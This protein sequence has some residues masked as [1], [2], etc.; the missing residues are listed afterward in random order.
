MSTLKAR[1]LL[2]LSII[3]SSTAAQAQNSNEILDEAAAASAYSK[4]SGTTIE[5]STRRLRIQNNLGDTIGH[6]R[7][8]FHDIIAGI[9]IEDRPDQHIVVR[10]KG[11][12]EPEPRKISTPY[13]IMPIV[14]HAN[15]IKSISELSGIIEANRENISRVI[16][17]LQDIYPDERT[18]EIVL[19]I[20][21]SNTDKAAYRAE[22][23]SIEKIL[24]APVRFEFVSSPTT[25]V[26]YTLGGA[27]LQANGS[28]CTTGFAV[29][30]TISNVRGI[31]TAGH[32]NDIQRYFNLYPVT[33]PYHVNFPLTF[34]AE[35]QD[36]SRDMQWH[37]VG[38]GFPTPLGDIYGSSTV[39][40][41]AILF[42]RERNS[43]AI[44]Q[45]VC[46]RGTTTGY[47]CGKVT[48]IM[49]STSAEVCGGPCTPTWVEV[50]GPDLACSPG[51]SG[52]P[53]HY[54]NTAFG[55]VSSASF[56][57]ML[58]GQCGRIVYMSLDYLSSFGLRLL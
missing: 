56:T 31:L 57:G 14:F 39:S 40:T 54:G 36:A 53:V 33:D 4:D 10:L 15:A 58:T 3:F 45:T 2:S 32:C 26:G 5:E 1:A 6:L 25:T 18:G 8:E 55:I 34:V 28:T 22:A 37:V 49:A 38:A 35:I 19:T 50:K 9:Y 47:S 41:T 30:N 17:D 16:P 42:R 44:G 48:S 11:N 23:A 43:T 12:I 7:E 24:G 27:I 13:G 20:Y 21:S 52:G 29:K 51:D 46:H